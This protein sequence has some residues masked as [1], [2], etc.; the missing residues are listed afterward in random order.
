MIGLS[1][2]NEKRP[3]SWGAIVF[4]A[5][6]FFAA[7]FGTDV[8][9][10]LRL[11]AAPIRT[12]GVCPLPP[13]VRPKGYDPENS[14]VLKILHD[15]DFRK[16]SVDKLSKAVQVDTQIYD[17][18]P[19]VDSNPE[20]WANF[21]MFHQYLE[22]A[23][24]LVHEHLELV[25]VN[26]YGLVYYWKGSDHKLK[27]V[28]LAGHQDV[29]PV[30]TETL[31][32]W[33]YPPFDGHYDGTYV[34]GRGSCDCKNVVVAIME[35]LE[36]LLQE[37]FKPKRGILVAFGFDEEATG[38]RGA[39]ELG[40]YLLDRFG[41]DGIFAIVD[42]GGWLTYDPT[43]G[44]VVA[45]VGTGEKGYVDVD[46]G[47]NTPGGHSS[48]PP[49]HTSIGIMGELATII[50]DDKYDPIFT[51]KNPFFGYM[52]CIAVHAGDKLSPSFRKS[53]LR[54]GFDKL[55]NSQVVKALVGSRSTK[56]LIGTSQAEDIV[57]GGEKNNALPETTHMIVNHRVAVETE[58]DVVLDH[59]VERV[60]K[61]AKKHG[62]GVDAWGKE[63]VA[64]GDKGKFEVNVAGHKLE[65]APVSPPHGE[66]WDLLAGVTR[67]VYEELVF[68][69]SEE[70]VIIAPAI[71]T[72]NTDTR[73]YWKLTKNIYRYTPQLYRDLIGETHIHSVDEKQ[74]MENHLRVLT[75][76]YQYLQAV[77]D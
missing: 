20:Y 21:E 25:K 74:D 47:L 48:L 26:T 2:D 49:E 51:E 32:Q 19:P 13:I 46:V 40:K 17:S 34:Y 77:S 5:V 30:Q 59:F 55:A 43:T 27:P 9:R 22:T 42:E 4:P 75:F 45:S 10:H 16:L 67:H 68:P 70:P 52:Q 69:E 7:F 23:F 8:F 62:L 38:Y 61:L 54:S 24:P 73:H 12:D 57:R 53:I 29:V 6:V 18:P 1:S 44:R 31:H 28:M 33:T 58:V 50:E 56:Y 66:S 3:R 36:L 41:P 39:I 63:I 64:A 35:S 14:T 72:G 15:P 65:A 76:Y 37:N 11:W 60:V 71:L